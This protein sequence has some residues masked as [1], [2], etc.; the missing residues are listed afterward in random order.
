MINTRRICAAYFEYGSNV[1]NIVKKDL[2]YEA[3]ITDR[4]TY[5]G[6]LYDFFTVTVFYR[7]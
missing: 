1:E 4:E 5:A 3:Y 7:L 2:P 6:T